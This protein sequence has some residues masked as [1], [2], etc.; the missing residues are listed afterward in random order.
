MQEGRGGPWG[1]GGCQAG[2]GEQVGEASGVWR[3]RT[4]AEKVEGGIV[5]PVTL[6]VA[7]V[8]FSGAVSVACRNPLGI[9][10][11]SLAWAVVTEAVVVVV[12]L[13]GVEA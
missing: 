12:T 10:G 13:G 2:S 8:V 6:V 3:A 9:T 1:G 7:L 11:L 4:G 5:E